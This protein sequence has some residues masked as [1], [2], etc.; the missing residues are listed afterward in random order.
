MKDPKEQKL[1]KARDKANRKLVEADR[2]LAEAH[3]KLVEA[4][5]K[6]NEINCK[7]REYQREQEQKGE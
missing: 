3:R 4:T 5:R 1:I 2:K 7:L 6:W